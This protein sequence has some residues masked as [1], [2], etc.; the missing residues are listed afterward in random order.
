M[1]ETNVESSTSLPSHRVSGRDYPGEWARNIEL[2]L[3]REQRRL[4]LYG[5]LFGVFVLAVVIV[6][7]IGVIGDKP[8]I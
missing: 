7:V 2:D 1:T 6:A 8:P 4:V 3:D 5:G